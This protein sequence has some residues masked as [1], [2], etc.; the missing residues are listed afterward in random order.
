MS[1]LEDEASRQLQ[2]ADERDEAIAASNTSPEERAM[3]SVVGIKTGEPVEP[4]ETLS[5]AL[6][7]LL[8]P[9]SDEE[10][11][12]AKT[13]HPHVFNSGRRGIFPVGEVTVVGARGRE[14]KTT[15]LTAVAVAAAVGR[16]LANLHGSP[17]TSVIYS[18]EDDRAQYARKIGAQM[19]LL[20]GAGRE[21]VRSRILVPDLD[22]PGMAGAKELVTTFDRAPVPTGAVDALIEAL[23]P[24]RDRHDA[25]LRTI[26]FE[27]AST[28]SDAEEDNRGHKVMI[29]ALKR[30]ARE[31]QV[32]VVLVHHTSQTADANLADLNVSSND[33]RGGT[34]L[35][36][37][38]RQT[39]L[40]VNLGSDADP[41]PETDARTVLRHMVCD[42]N[43]S[44]RQHRLLA[45]ICLDSSKSAAPPPIF[46][47]WVDTDFDPAAVEYVAPDHLADRP[48]RKVHEMVR[49]ERIQARNE[50]RAEAKR[51]A[52]SESVRRVVEIAT[53]LTEQGLQATAARVSGAANRS[54]TWA[55]PHLLAAVTARLLVPSE[56]PVPRCRGLQTVY[57][58]ADST[59][60][61]G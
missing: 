51:D 46:F 11:E 47:R 17:S 13:P 1:R 59:A 3:A 15:V 36:F 35:V 2:R 55:T 45:M 60:S 32:A 9:W 57:R 33:I 42:G 22:S 26:I 61:A 44:D 30:I 27:T 10:I 34:S 6:R 23:E 7:A 53:S 8:S 52:A 41:F 31:L 24:L 5:D 25:P 49:A 43:L 20:A 12:A 39:W 58:P 4:K 28:L 18:A 16:S 56:E 21:A 48:W 19:Q 29:A 54:P 38:A 37:N 14:G 50:L 40:L